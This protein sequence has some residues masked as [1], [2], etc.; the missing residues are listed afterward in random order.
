MNRPAIQSPVPWLDRWNIPQADVLLKPY[1]EL[2]L[3]LAEDMMQAILDL[4][5]VEQSI[6]WHGDSW[7]WTFQFDLVS[8][9]VEQGLCYLIPNPETFM[10]VIPMHRDVIAKL[11]M[12]RL[13]RYVRDAIR[14]SKCAVDLHWTLWRPTLKSE[15]EHLLDLVKRK[16]KLLLE[17]ENA[18]K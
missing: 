3:K 6:V 5:Q 15:G 12:R 14:S 17:A 13:N 18:G 16:R 11:P 7:R 10:F 4:G 8:S 1:N 2:T 9:Q